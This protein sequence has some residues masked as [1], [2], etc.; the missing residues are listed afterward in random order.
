MNDAKKTVLKIKEV[1]TRKNVQPGYPDANG[2]T[3]TTWCNRG[4]HYVATE[5]GFDMAPFLDARGINWTTANAMYENAVKNAK[6]VYPREAQILAND[7][8]LVLA[9][10]FNAK[11]SGHVAIVC[12][13]EEEYDD[14]L[15]PLV[16]E[17][18][19][20]CRITHSKAAFEKYGY[21]ARF[22]VIPEKGGV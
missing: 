8:G 22:F 15:G 7:G 10:C 19:A 11:G 1:I 20:K 14:A 18:G 3:A 12:P 2:N 17:S 6:E 21:K 9:A 4:A 16:G 13:A 5:L